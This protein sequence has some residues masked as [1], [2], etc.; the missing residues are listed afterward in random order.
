MIYIFFLKPHELQNHGLK[1]FEFFSPYHLALILRAFKKA[2]G[3]FKIFS[4][5]E[6][7]DS[8]SVT[9]EVQFSSTIMQAK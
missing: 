3:E 1:T 2:L 5:F 6:V 9:N 7:S 8:I 4:G